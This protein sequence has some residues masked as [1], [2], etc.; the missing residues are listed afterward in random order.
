MIELVD[1][2]WVVPENVTVIKKI[3]EEKCALWVVGQSA[4]D[5][6]VLDYPAEEVVEALLDAKYGGGDED[7]EEDET[8][9]MDAGNGGA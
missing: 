4:M 2:F 9:E 8:E 6:F 3:D 5:G 1:G 7:D